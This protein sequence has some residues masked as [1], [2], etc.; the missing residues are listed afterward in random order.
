MPDAEIVPD[1]IQHETVVVSTNL[2]KEIVNEA[3]DTEKLEDERK[4]QKLK[5]AEQK[6]EGTVLCSSIGTNN[7]YIT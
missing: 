1:G 3:L 6:A 4:I 2:E 7:V 5:M